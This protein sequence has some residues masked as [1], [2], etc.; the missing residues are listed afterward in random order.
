[1][2]LP[3]FGSDNKGG[4][5]PAAWFQLFNVVTVIL[6]VP[7]VDRFVYPRLDVIFKRAPHLF[8]MAVGK[9]PSCFIHIFEGQI[10]EVTLHV[11][12]GKY[13]VVQIHIGRG[14]SREEYTQLARDSF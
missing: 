10:I 7:F 8:R 9:K 11:G 6:L 4:G 5:V 2:K 1:M 3:S 12:Y 13:Q 14:V